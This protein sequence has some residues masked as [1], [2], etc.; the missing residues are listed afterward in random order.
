MMAVEL[1]NMMIEMDLRVQ[2]LP[3]MGAWTVGVRMIRR[4]WP[5]SLAEAVAPIAM[6]QFSENVPLDR[7]SGME[8][9]DSAL[10]VSFRCNGNFPRLAAK[11]FCMVENSPH[12]QPDDRRAGEV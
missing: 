10:V 11:A 8:G 4:T 7:K 3:A 6:E 9:L 12:E 2:S 1:N 5:M